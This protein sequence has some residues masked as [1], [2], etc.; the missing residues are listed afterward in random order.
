MLSPVLRSPLLS[1]RSSMK[2][3]E[4]NLSDPCEEEEQEEE[5]HFVSCERETSA[6]AA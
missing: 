3:H 2:I 1:P 5:Q 6:S 4:E